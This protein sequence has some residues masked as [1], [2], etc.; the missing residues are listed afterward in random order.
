M[1][2]F[3][4]PQACLLLLLESLTLT[5]SNLNL[6]PNPQA[7][8]LLL[9]ESPYGAGTAP[10]RVRSG[11][12]AAE[13]VLSGAGSG[14]KGA[15][16]HYDVLNSHRAAPP[17]EL[18]SCYRRMALLL[19]PDKN[20]EERAAVAFKRV[21]E[22]WDVLSHP[23]GRAEYD[24]T[25]DGGGSLFDDPDTEPAAD[26]PFVPPDAGVANLPPGVKKR[27]AKPPGVRRRA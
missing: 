22:A 17:S 14:E 11:E 21:T 26:A 18:K 12:V 7:R 2:M 9:L 3:M 25:L 19:H 27:R 24:A 15:Q 5:L 13:L 8:L 10:D 4:C 1:P 16:T 20:P 23:A 6:N